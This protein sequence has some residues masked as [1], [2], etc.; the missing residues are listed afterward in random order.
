[1]DE[2][3]KIQEKRRDQEESA[4]SSRANIL[5]MDYANLKSIEK[6]LPVISSVLS[7]QDMYRNHIIPLAISNGIEPWKFGITVQTPQSFVRQMKSDYSNNG[8]NI[9]FFL[10]SDSSF[11]SMMLRYDPPKEIKYENIKISNENDDSTLKQV[12]DILNGVPIDSVF[13]YLINQ[14][15]KLNAS[16]IHIENQRE[17][18]RIRIRVDGVLHAVAYLKRDRYRVIMDTVASRANLS[19]AATESQSGHIQQ[20][21]DSG[22]ILNIRIEMIPTL[23]GQDAVL[24]LFNFDQSRLD[25]DKLGLTKWQKQEIDKIIEH[26]KGMVLMVGPTGSGKS[27]TLYSIINRLN[28]SE[29]K[30]I[31]LE[32]PI[33]YG[34]DG[35]T[36]IPVNTTG[37][38][39]FADEL[40]SVL[41]LDPDV[42]MVGEI[43][44]QDTA[45]TAIQASITGHL[46]LSSFHASSTSAAFS[47]MID[48]IGVNPIFSS[49][50]RLVVAQRLIRRLNDKTKVAYK[51]D[52]ATI[53]W[54][55]SV[56]DGLPESVIGVDLNDFRLY[57]AVG[58]S[59]YPFGYVGRTAIVE[60]M[61]VNEGIQKFIRGD[62]RSYDQSIVEEKARQDGMITLLQSG[63]IAAVNGLTT[64]D[65]I[66]K[67][68]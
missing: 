26:P 37:G 53:N 17:A 42:I 9:K 24:R 47:R 64:I 55:K 36:Q 51:P 34:V 27:T 23:Y 62:I 30:I 29:R 38:Q 4:T 16:D 65:E 67:V 59:E 41:R 44:D 33:E 49:A 57:R 39:S 45:K 18:I 3:S 46:V 56:L 50:I 48:L 52:T 7:V 68:I 12:S 31:T 2:E 11:R 28:S 63:V 35:I 61:V 14:A 13:D 21:T 19:S 25:L 15:S 22:A 5:G 43:R 54:V 1:M 32:D 66:N 40:R 8:K 10:I 60:Q 20:K 6:T 58:D